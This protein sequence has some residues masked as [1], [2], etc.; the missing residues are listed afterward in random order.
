[1]TF[2][3]YDNF[4]EVPGHSNPTENLTISIWAKSNIENWDAI[5]C[6]V[7][8]RNAF[9]FGPM[10]EKML[11]M[12]IHSSEGW[13]SIEYT[14]PL[15]TNIECWH[16]YASVFNGSQLFLYVDGIQVATR[17]HDRTI[18]ANTRHMTIGWDDYNNGIKRH[19]DGQIAEVAICI[20]LS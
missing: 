3:G 7:S 18:S 14:L 6:F 13:T 4:I 12:Y 2:N 19:L 11:R 16:H 17:N 1:M 20:Y 10:D 9:I 5:G 8:K 15:E